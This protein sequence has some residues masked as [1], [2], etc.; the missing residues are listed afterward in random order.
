MVV[1]LATRKRTAGTMDAYVVVE[2]K[3]MKE[4]VSIGVAAVSADE[5]RASSSDTVVLDIIKAYPQAVQY[6]PDSFYI[7]L[8]FG[9][10][11]A[12]QLLC[13]L[14]QELVYVPRDDPRLQFKIFNAINQLPRDKSFLGDVSDEVAPTI[15]LQPSWQQPVP[16]CVAVDAYNGVYSSASGHCSVHLPPRSQQVP[17]WS[18]P[19]RIPVSS[20]NVQ[21]HYAANKLW[22]SS[23]TACRST[24]FLTLHIVLSLCAVTIK[25]VT[26]SWTAVC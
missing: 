5:L 13:R 7:P 18:G 12:D 26:F 6:G 20:N 3:K 19:H 22:Y 24:C 15:P 16:R 1:P 21:A 17:Q 23:H 4:D 8:Y 25:T 10:A 9:S 11:E 14:Q 2:P